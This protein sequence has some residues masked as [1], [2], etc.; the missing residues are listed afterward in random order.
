MDRGIRT[1]A[2]TAA[3]IA[4]ITVAI[5]VQGRRATVS[6][7]EMTPLE[8][9]VID[10]S[11]A[12]S[13]AL[14]TLPPALASLFDV[15]PELAAGAGDACELLESRYD[16]DQRRRVRLTT[17]DSGTITLEVLANAA[18]GALTRVEF[19]RR[20]PGNGQRRLI[21]DGPSDRTVSLWWTQSSS[22]IRRRAEQ[23]NIPRGG[24]VPRVLRALGRQLLT[25]P[26]AE[27]ERTPR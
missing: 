1:A 7:A 3:I 5:V 21:W 2:L 18:T 12:D 26:C 10:S 20:V 8:Q 17:R 9:L 25:V 16:G 15:Q 23:G 27:P 6:A 24:P 13:A 22:G 11:V 19:T 14:A 4:A